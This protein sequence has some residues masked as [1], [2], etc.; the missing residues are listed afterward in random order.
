MATRYRMLDVPDQ[1]GRTFLVT[2]ANAGIGFEAA[3]VLAGLGG[4]VILGCRDAE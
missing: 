4:R 2:G 1:T 3:K